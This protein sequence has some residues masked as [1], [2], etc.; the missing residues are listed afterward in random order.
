LSRA[1][2]NKA[3][4]GIQSGVIVQY[5]ETTDDGKE[6]RKFDERE[7]DLVYEG[8]VLLGGWSKVLRADRKV[9]FY[10]RL[11]LGTYNKGTPQ[12]Q[13]D[14]A[15]MIVKCAQSAALREAFPTVLGGLYL[16]DEIEAFTGAAGSAKAPQTGAGGH[17]TLDALS[18]KLPADIGAS[19]G[20]EQHEPAAGE[21]HSGEGDPG[22]DQTTLDSEPSQQLKGSEATGQAT[23]GTEAEGNGTEVGPE[24]AGDFDPEAELNNWQFD[25][26]Q[27]KTNGQLDRLAEEAANTWPQIK[28]KVLELIAKQRTKLAGGSK[29][30]PS[31]KQNK[32]PGA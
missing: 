21:Q 32:L 26:E 17:Y 24:T 13:Q 18:G 15:G 12:W 8:E 16:K 28:M 2:L 7:G 25:I 27:V 11:K 20:H 3:F 31:S 9:P 1:E 23:G 5:T 10:Q 6:I 14:G 22:I 30:P 4:E 19:P 29:T